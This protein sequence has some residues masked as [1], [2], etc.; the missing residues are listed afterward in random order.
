MKPNY[1]VRSAEL[2][3]GLRQLSIVGLSVVALLLVFGSSAK[4][5]LVQNGSFEN[6]TLTN[7]GYFN[8]FSPSYGG[9]GLSNVANWTVNCAGTLYSA[10]AGSCAPGDP[11][12]V[13]VV[14]NT[15]PTAFSPG[16]GLYGPGPTPATDAIPPSPD[17]GNFVAEDGNAILN[18]SFS[19]QISG[20]NPGSA[21]VLSFYQA[22]TQQLG[23][24]GATTEQWQVS[25]GSQTEDSTLMS[26]PSQSFTPWAQQTLT[27]TATSSSEAL[28]FLALG[29]PAGLP[30]IALLDGV[31]LT[32]ATPEPSYATLMGAGL[33]GLWVARRIYHRKQS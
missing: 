30:P 16:N 8:Q 6:T 13:L 22:A 26:N 12:L 33:L 24:S 20:L 4:A 11:L 7:T 3:S 27:F 17:G 9:T 32:A 10:N 2:L 14:P 29:S 23:M 25:L 5:S 15:S 18:T 28:T 21:Y 19:Q 31:S 1:A